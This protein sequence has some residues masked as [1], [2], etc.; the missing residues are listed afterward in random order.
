MRGSFQNNT[1]RRLNLKEEKDRF[2]NDEDQAGQ[3]KKKTLVKQMDRIVRDYN[4]SSGES[5]CQR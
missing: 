5:Q 2:V 3:K 1:F 4:L